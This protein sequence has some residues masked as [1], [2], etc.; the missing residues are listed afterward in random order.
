MKRLLLLLLVSGLSLLFAA[1]AYAQSYDLEPYNEVDYAIDA[2]GLPYAFHDIA[3]RESGD[4]PYATNGYT[5]GPFQFLVDSAWRMQ[6]V[7]TSSR[8][9]NGYGY[10]CA[11]L[12][13]PYTA[14][15]AAKELYEYAGYSPWVLTAW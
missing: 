14:A 1:P 15:V 2:V 5:C 7:P 13:D 6:Y 12:T 9:G 10:T 11:E 8:Y 3:W 4:D